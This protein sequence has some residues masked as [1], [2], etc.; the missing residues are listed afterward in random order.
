VATD[1]GVDKRIQVFSVDVQRRNAAILISGKP[2][3]GGHPN[4]LLLYL[5]SLSPVRFIVSP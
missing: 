3:R 2:K 5:V 1:Q 4:S